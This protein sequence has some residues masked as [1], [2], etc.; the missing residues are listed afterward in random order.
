MEPLGERACD[1][2]G[3]GKLLNLTPAKIGGIVL[4]VHR[5]FSSYICNSNS[6]P[7]AA[8]SG[9]SPFIR[10]DQGE[11]SGTDHE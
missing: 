5:H 11:I 10:Q 6:Q 7:G 3:R 1:F 2:L 4:T 9:T 8:T